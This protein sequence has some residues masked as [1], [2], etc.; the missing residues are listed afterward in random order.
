M[1]VDIFSYTTSVNA[2]EVATKALS[3][4]R[5]WVKNYDYEA[6]DVC[7]FNNNFFL[8][9]YSHNSGTSFNTSAWTKINDSADKL[10]GLDVTTNTKANNRVLTYD[11][12]TNA[13][14]FKDIPSQIDDAVT[15]SATKTYSINKIK[16]LNDLKVDKN[17]IG[18]ANG[19]PPL[20]VNGKIPSQ[21]LSVTG[22]GNVTYVKNTITERDA[23]TGLNTGD[24]CIVLVSED[25]SREGFVWDGTQWLKDSDSDWVN[26][27]IDYNNI[28]NKPFIPTK[29]SDLTK[30]D[31][32]TTNEI[33][34]IVGSEALLT[35]S[36]T[37]KGAIN[38]VFQSGSNVKANV[39]TAVT[40]KGQPVTTQNTWS[41]IVAAISNI[42][43][44]T[45]TGSANVKEVTKL[46]VIASESTPY[47]HIV[48]LDNPIVN[49]DI[50]YGVREFV[51]GSE[52]TNLISTFN[53]ADSDDFKPNQS[54][55]FDG[56]IKL[57]D[58]I[59]IEDMVDEGVL[60]TG[61]LY[62]FTVNKTSYNRIKNVEVVDENIPQ[63]K[64]TTLY[65]EAV[66]ESNGDI[67]LTNVE[68]WNSIIFNTITTNGGKCLLA[69][70][71]DGGVTYK[72][73]NIGLGAWQVVDIT[74]FND[75][76]KK[77]MSKTIT[78]S[79]TSTEL[80][81][82]RNGS[83]KV[84]FAYYLSVVDEKSIAESS[85]I[86]INVAMSGYYVLANK[87]DYDVLIGEDNQS[88][89]FK[90]YKSGTYTMKCA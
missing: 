17:L 80:E 20:D 85:D 13:I 16:Q 86:S 64:I 84:R 15:E 73:Y 75:F 82:L 36:Q 62:T 72:A 6:Q 8:A 51:G 41:E 50:V 61:N 5:Q 24:A 90:F 66:L 44:G 22:N 33:N 14:T 26:I 2:A 52:L 70:S 65:N 54:I 27:N 3:Q 71:V 55:L 30:D 87:N 32:Y 68:T 43:V 38:E 63:I 45:S 18:V 4:A 47:T 11:E 83:K 74:N 56:S 12:T 21:F 10:K 59:V 7:I 9:N 78:D 89:E 67:D 35:K 28:I 79:L 1:A 69:V 29:T 23:L 34:N 60:D 37:L 81:L 53:N 42:K 48:A 31:V 39:V 57:A 58:K 25:G 19:I 77:G 46:N 40:S 88:I 76:A 49:N